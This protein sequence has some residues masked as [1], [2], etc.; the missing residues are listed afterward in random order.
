MGLFGSS[1]IR[2]RPRDFVIAQLDKIFSSSFIDAETKGFT[3]LSQE[4]P[5]LKGISL[6]KYIIERQNVI[7]NLFCIAWDRNIPYKLFI[8]CS[9]IIPND[10]RVESVNTGAYDG[11]LSKAQEAGMSTFGYISKIFIS[12]IV[13]NDISV[14]EVDYKK[15]Y[16]IYGTDFTELY[17]SFESL[18][19]QY[20]FI[21]D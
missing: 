20:K 12:Q 8:E 14:I 5:F 7:C 1:K 13:P 10:P 6:E 3:Q 9:S 11:A 15:I 18:I 2:I 16:E 19:K 4:I 21:Q 17:I